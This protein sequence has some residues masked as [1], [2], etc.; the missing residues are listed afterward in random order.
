MRRES[1]GEKRSARIGVGMAADIALFLQANRCH[2]YR[3]TNVRAAEILSRPESHDKQRV[4]TFLYE[5]RQ[6]RS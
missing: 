6:Y 3:N 5:A 4:L 2:K 1:G